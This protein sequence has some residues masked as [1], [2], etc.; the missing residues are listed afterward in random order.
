MTNS[1]WT[2]TLMKDNRFWE[3]AGLVTILVVMPS[4]IVGMTAMIPTHDIWMVA[5]GIALARVFDV[6]FWFFKKTA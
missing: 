2:A 1:D 3:T 5:L 6:L 4:F